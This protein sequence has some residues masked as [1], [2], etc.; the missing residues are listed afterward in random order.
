VSDEVVSR[1]EQV[2]DER[3]VDVEVHALDGQPRR[4]PGPLEHHEL[5]ALRERLLRPPGRRTPDEAAV[6]EDEPL[7]RGILNRV[8]NSSVSRIKMP[9]QLLQAR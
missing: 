9:N 3:G 1:L 4:K 2:R 5:E 6:H 7:H 8:T